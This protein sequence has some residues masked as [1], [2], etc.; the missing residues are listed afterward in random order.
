MRLVQSNWQPNEGTKKVILAVGLESQG[1]SFI[2]V[3]KI[4]EKMG[5]EVVPV[6]EVLMFDLKKFGNG[7]SPVRSARQLLALKVFFCVDKFAH[8][9]SI[10][11]GCCFGKVVR[12]HLSNQ[13]NIAEQLIRDFAF[14]MSATV[15]FG[16]NGWTDLP[17]VL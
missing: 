14:G 6:T 11:S 10:N 13:G 9:H 4:L 7:L 2:A 1:Q 15:A 5:H 12:H 16:G 17:Q 8:D 3:V